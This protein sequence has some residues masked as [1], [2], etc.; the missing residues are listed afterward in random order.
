MAG[1]SRPK[2]V[3]AHILRDFKLSGWEDRLNHRWDYQDLRANPLWFKGW[4]SFDTVTW[5][6]KD[7]KLYCGLNSLDGDLLHC[8][9]PS[10]PQFESMNTQQWTD[11]YDV[12]I[13]RTLLLN[14]KDQCFYFATSLLHDL[15][16]QQAAKGGKLVRFD[17]QTRQYQVIGV[18]VP[19]LYIQSI[20]ADWERSIIYGFTYPAEA[21]FKTDLRTGSSQ[22]LAYIGNATMLVQPHN[23]VVDREG[24]LWGTYAET[25][26]WDETIGHAPVRLFKYH[27]DRNEFVWFEH[28]LRRRKEEQQLLADPPVPEGTT[29]ALAETRHHED[30]GFCDSM[31]YDGERYIY[32]GTVAGVL[33]RIDTR[34]GEVEKIAN[35]MSTTRFPGLAIK[36][37]I[38]YGGGGM[39][40]CT[41]LIRWNTK[42]DRIELYSD[43]VEQRINDRPERIHE[44]AVDD[45]H[46][47]F[48]AENDNNR[49][50]SYLWAVHLD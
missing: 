21:V 1:N 11:R 39:K 25:R 44:L 48:L 9:S 26:A 40:G 23:A 33:N 16:Q 41:Q 28:G 3:K 19:H 20:A 50:S 34:T 7:K 17:P 36:E 29:S 32:A 2:S 6:P 18:P 37:G 46:Q 35:A 14:P 15:D 43:L 49:R 31:A 8:F 10:A 47:I 12:K 27:P 30:Y 38:I 42:T 4:I 22:I 13:H 45:E 5:N 24:W